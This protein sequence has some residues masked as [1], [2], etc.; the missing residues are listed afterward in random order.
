M[1]T[2]V[3][4]HLSEILPNREKPIILL[5]RYSHTH[6]SHAVSNSRV[7]ERLMANGNEQSELMSMAFCCSIC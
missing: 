1:N 2:V 6:Y 7:C 5:G 4:A 3:A